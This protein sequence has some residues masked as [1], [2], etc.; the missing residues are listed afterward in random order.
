MKAGVETLEW[1]MPSDF[2]WFRID[3]S[4]LFPVCD[5]WFNVWWPARDLLS[6]S[7]REKYEGEVIYSAQWMDWILNDTICVGG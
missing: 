4:S 6:N 5:E 1:A 2:E 7:L 3:G